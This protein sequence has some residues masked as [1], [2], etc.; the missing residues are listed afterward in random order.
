GVRAGSGALRQLHADLE[1]AARV[2]GASWL[3]MIRWI[4]V[5]LT[6]PTLIATWTLVFILS[7][8]E[9]SSSI[10][11]YTS[12]TVVLSVAA[13]DLGA[14]GS[15]AAL[16][17]VAVMQLAITFLALLLLVRARHHELLA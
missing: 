6:R 9:D 16:A 2:T 1:D 17:A 11:L 13:F 8:Q 7:M 10:L 15:V 14:A 5:P 12:R 4:T 3:R